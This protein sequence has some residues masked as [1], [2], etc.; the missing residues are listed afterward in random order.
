MTFF[1]F[2]FLKKIHAAIAIAVSAT[3]IAIKTPMG[4]QSNTLAIKYASGIWKT[5][6]PTKWIHVGVRVSPAPF[7]AWIMTM[8]IP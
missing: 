6:N 2:P 3:G 7:K 4:P 1:H 5:Q 8:P